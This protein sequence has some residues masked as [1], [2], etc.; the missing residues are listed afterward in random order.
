[1]DFGSR[2][3]SSPGFCSVPGEN[4][5]NYIIDH[6]GSPPKKPTKKPTTQNGTRS[7]V[8]RSTM[9]TADV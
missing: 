7:P 3:R 2:E 6:H 1:M 9:D 5:N 4:M 8:K